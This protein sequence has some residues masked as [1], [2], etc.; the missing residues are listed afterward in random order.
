[1]ISGHRTW[2]LVRCAVDTGPLGL[3]QSGKTIDVVGFV[4]SYEKRKEAVFQK[5]AE[6]V[7]AEMSRKRRLWRSFSNSLP[8][9]AVPPSAS[10]C[11]RLRRSLRL[12]KTS[13]MPRK[14][15]PVLEMKHPSPSVSID[16]SLRQKDP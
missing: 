15:D 8:K 6:Q 2:S 5:N 3:D 11:S 13:R 16:P 10:P 9:A 1:M 7:R 12:P 14:T 4:F